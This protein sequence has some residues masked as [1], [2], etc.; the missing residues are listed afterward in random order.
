VWRGWGGPLRNT[1]GDDWYGFGGAWGEVSA[2][3]ILGNL[4][5]DLTTGPLGPPHKDPGSTLF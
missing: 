2:P 3:A 1:T 4:K 5:K